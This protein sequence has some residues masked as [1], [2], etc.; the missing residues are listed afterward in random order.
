[1]NGGPKDETLRQSYTVLDGYKKRQM[2]SH[3]RFQNVLNLDNQVPLLLCTPWNTDATS[4]R[5]SV[6]CDL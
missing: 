3:H 1:M 5:A 6:V 4:R 2:V